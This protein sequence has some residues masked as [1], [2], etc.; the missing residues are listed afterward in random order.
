MSLRILDILGRPPLCIERAM[1][2]GTVYTSISGFLEGPGL[3]SRRV[4]LHHWQLR[5][6]LRGKHAKI[7]RKRRVSLRW[8]FSHVRN[9]VRKLRPRLAGCKKSRWGLLLDT[10]PEPERLARQVKVIQV[11][12]S[13]W[14]ELAGL[15]CVSRAGKCA[16][17]EHWSFCAS[18]IRPQLI[19]D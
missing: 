3:L 17:P 13:S 6:N 16:A 9:A 14:S 18:R 1:P 5:C 2:L 19:F 7:T 8:T 10:K 4:T 15:K 12:F 11:C